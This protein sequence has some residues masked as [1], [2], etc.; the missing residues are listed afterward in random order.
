MSQTLNKIYDAYPEYEFVEA[1][2]F[3]DAVIG[4]DMDTSRLIYSASKCIDILVYKDGM[5]FEDAVEYFEEKVRA[6]F[7]DNEDGPIW[8]NVD[9]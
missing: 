5:P 3:K 1:P 8:A 2:G 4:V 7:E 6:A 9:F